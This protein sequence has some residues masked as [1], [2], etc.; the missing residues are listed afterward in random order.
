MSAKM[1]NGYEE[2]DRVV[3]SG[4]LS[5]LST[6]ERINYYSA[7]CKSLG[8]NPL[9]R[10]F[11]YITLQDKKTLKS[12]LTLYA[13]KDCTEQLRSIKGIS[14]NI[15]SREVINDVYVVTARATDKSGRVDESLGAV[16]VKGLF[17]E[18]LSNAYMRAETKAK[19][20][21]TLSIAG[22]GLPD[23]SEIG[24]IPNAVMHKE[25]PVAKNP[26]HLLESQK[27]SE[28]SLQYIN[29]LIVDCNITESELDELLKKAKVSSISDL[30]QDRAEKFIEFLNKRLNHGN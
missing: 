8:L 22:L 6:E 28:K 23:E 7:V 2:L 10:P 1:Q 24:S 4:D 29:Q 14:L 27:V 5:N 12:K 19:R 21:V 30:S 16:P 3:V 13:R 18:A 11:E 15:V 25:I 26:V 17:G 20:R 9:T